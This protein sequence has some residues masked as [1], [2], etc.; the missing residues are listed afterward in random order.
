MTTTG[1]YLRSISAAPIGSTALDCLLDVSGGGSGGAL[2]VP[3]DAVASGGD[4]AVIVEDDVLVEAT[5]ATFAY[6]PQDQII[7]QNAEVAT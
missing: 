5:G 6:A 7:A 3:G 2:I 1:Q 4:T